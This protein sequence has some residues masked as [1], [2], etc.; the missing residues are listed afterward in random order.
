MGVAV[1]DDIRL[2]FPPG[3][4]QVLQAVLHPVQIPMGAEEALAPQLQK[5]GFGDIRLAAKIA[6]A[7]HPFAEGIREE[8]ARL[9]K[10]LR[11]VP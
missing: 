4:H 11:P 6:I 7:P 8:P 9:L 10:V 1:K 2:L 5:E 3:P